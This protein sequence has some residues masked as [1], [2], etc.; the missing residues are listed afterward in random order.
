MEENSTLRTTD[1]PLTTTNEKKEEP[2]KEEQAEE[3]HGSLNKDILLFLFV[4]LSIGQVLKGVSAYT[5]IPY[6]SMVTIV[7]FIFGL[8]FKKL[9]RVGKA[10]EAYSNIDATFLLMLFLPALI[11][12]SSFNS[13]WHIFK[14]EMGQILIM[15][16]PM[17]IIATYL[18]AV[19]MYYILGY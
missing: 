14:K 9:G 10:V 11:F 15:A 13:D 16:G 17:L 3:A 19:M 1:V 5:T 6:T 18:S 8:Y 7:G 12:E 2:K 4:S